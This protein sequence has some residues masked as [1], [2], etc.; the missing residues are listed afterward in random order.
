MKILDKLISKISTLFLVVVAAIF[1]ILPFDVVGIFSLNNINRAINTIIGNYLYSIGGVIILI[2]SIK[3]LFSRITK[4]SNRQNHIV[5][6]MNFGDLRISDEAIEGL[7]Q[8]VI[9]RIVGIRSSK[10]A[11]DFSDGYIFIEIKGQVAPEVNIP[12][13]TDEIQNGV[14]DTVESHTGIQVSRVN[15]DILSISS[16]TKSLK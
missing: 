9:S 1:I 2:L 16:A 8:N 13:I 12:S 5:T 7:T 10:I 6:P 3:S 4:N 15:V 14:K 11:V